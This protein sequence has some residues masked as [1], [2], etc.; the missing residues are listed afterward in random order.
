MDFDVSDLAPE[1]P[2]QYG[3][4]QE[5]TLYY[6]ETNNIRKLLL[7][8]RG[9]NVTKHDNFVLGGIVLRPGQNIGD[10]EELRRVLWIQKSAEEIK[11]DLVAKGSFER[12]LD[13]RKLGQTLHWL[14]E[15]DIGIHYDNLNILNW[16][17]LDIVESV[18]ADERFNEFLP[19]HREMKNELHRIVL[20]GL[21]PFLAMLRRYGYP[22]LTKGTAGHF[23]SEVRQFIQSHWP[24]HVFPATEMLNEMLLRAQ[25][26]QELAFLANKK[27]DYLIEG[28]EDFYLHRICNFRNSTHFF[29]EEPTVQAAIG[30]IRIVDGN[31]EVS[32][33]FVDSKKVGEIQ[34]SD[35]VVGF[36]G[37]YFTFVEQ[38]PLPVLLRKRKEL[39]RMQAANLEL[40]AQ[41]IDISDKAS[42]VLLHRITTM[43]SD[44]KSDSF[45]FGREPPPHLLAA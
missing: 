45:L 35:V 27:R 44:W 34:L 39:T 19:F 26:T 22:D 21:Q 33:S 41:L 29:D 1:D 32:F 11:F 2:R 28:F 30:G 20:S 18:V 43:D 12:V 4:D 24:V 8:E 38:T 37:K 25:S 5:F 13:S 6:D 17:I 15:R 9:L 10:I 40:L 42:N 16:S 36:L 3:N 31:R 23:I 7:T 14:L